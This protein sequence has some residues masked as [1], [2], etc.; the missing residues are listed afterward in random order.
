MADWGTFWAKYGSTV[1]A[2]LIRHIELSLAAEALGFVIGMPA[3]ILLTRNERVAKAVLSVF[4]VLNTIP[5]LVMLGVA[6]VVLGLG[7]LPALFVLFVYSLLPIL[8][9][10]YTG[11]MGVE[12]R[13]LRAAKGMGM[14]EWQ[15]LTKVQLP[16]AAP[17]IIGGIRISMVYIISWATLG[18]FIGAGGL[19]DLI[20]SGLASYNIPLVFAGAIPATLL[21]LAMSFLIGMLQKA[22]TK[23]SFH[24]NAKGGGV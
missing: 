22:V 6:M 17:V 16:L 18:A 15:V 10:T 11:I 8:S 1:I 2:S 5:S 14:D 20:W 19:G 23:R 9:N 7:F 24:E 3:G 21:A 4:G 13:Y 12:E